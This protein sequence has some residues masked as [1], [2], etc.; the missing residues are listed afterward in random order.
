MTST[1]TRL[2]RLLFSG[3]SRR[4]ISGEART[5]TTGLWRALAA[6]LALQGSGSDGNP[7]WC[8]R[9][10]TYKKI[11]MLSK[12]KDLHLGLSM[13]HKTDLITNSRAWNPTVS[14][15]LLQTRLARP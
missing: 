1:F 8:G 4:D 11:V 13:R 9:S 2:S 10:V 14:Q 6:A 3:V 12:A 15:Q 5:L 7:A